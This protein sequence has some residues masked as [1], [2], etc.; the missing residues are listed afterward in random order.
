MQALRGNIRVICRIRPAVDAVEKACWT[1]TEESGVVTVVDAARDRTKKFEF[2]EACGPESSQEQV[3]EVQIP[4]NRRS[5][6]V[7]STHVQPG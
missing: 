3:F 5:L 6:S 2:N 7:L 1:S 4:Q